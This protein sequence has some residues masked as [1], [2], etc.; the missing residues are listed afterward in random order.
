MP[1]GLFYEES[2][3]CL[4]AKREQKLYRGFFIGAAVVLII[5]VIILV[6]AL[7]IVPGFWM[8]EEMNTPSRIV[9]TILWVGLGLS[10]FAMSFAFWKLKN[11][12][13]Q[14]FDYVFVEDELRIT[15]VFNG[16]RR[17]HVITMRA[18]EILK[19]GWCERDSFENTM[20]GMQG[21][22]PRIMTPNREPAEDKEFIYILVSIGG[23]KSLYVI[24][25]RQ[26]ML[27]YLVAAAGRTK[28]ERG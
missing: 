4:R 3:S 13:N 20:R 25:C 22:K 1:R 17:K 27:E 12:F 10:V 24:E 23:D 11:R 16:R 21:K 14:S 6:F 26:M 18:D 7:N 8:D 28:L 19:I 2:A 5:G 15:R 9:G